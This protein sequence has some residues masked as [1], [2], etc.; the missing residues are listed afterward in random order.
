[1]RGSLATAS[2]TTAAPR[3]L[4]FEHRQPGA[5]V[6]GHDKIRRQ[7]VERPFPDLAGE[8]VDD[9]TASAP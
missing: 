2:L 4:P 3:R 6:F 5:R 9:L 1:M 7:F 8:E